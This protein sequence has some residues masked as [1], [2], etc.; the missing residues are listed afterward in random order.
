MFKS[1]TKNVMYVKF[2]FGVNFLCESFQF[3]KKANLLM[4]PAFDLKSEVTGKK[5]L[6]TKMCPNSSLG[7]KFYPECNYGKPTH[8]KSWVVISTSPILYAW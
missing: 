2:V 8:A 4:N 3:F 1:C 7:S 6:G 5:R